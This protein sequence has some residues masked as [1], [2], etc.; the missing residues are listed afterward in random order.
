MEIKEL[1]QQI[2][3]DET[4]SHKL[5]KVVSID[6]NNATVDVEPVDDDAIIYGVRLKAIVD[7]SGAGV[8]LWPAE[9]SMVIVGVMNNDETKS[10]VEVMSSIDAFTLQMANGLT[11]DLDD[12]CN[13][14]LDVK[15]KI[16]INGGNNGDLIKI[17]ALTQELA[18][19]NQFLSAIRNGFNSWTPVTQDG[20][21]ALKITMASILSSQQTGNFN[22]IN[23]PDICH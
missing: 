19:I 11:A 22:N 3:K 8:T 12:Q 2:V 6:R 20:G 23:N 9:G 21:A 18:K 7:G 5:C 10:F 17:N 4:A 15:G 13:L 1:I 14:N 16:T